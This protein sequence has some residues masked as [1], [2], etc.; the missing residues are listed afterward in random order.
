MTGMAIL[1]PAIR[2]TFRCKRFRIT[3]GNALVDTGADETLLPLSMAND[4]GF[5]FD[6]EKDKVMWDGAGGQQFPA[7]KS[8][9]EIEFI[10]E[11]SGF[12]PCRWTSHVFFT[13]EQPTI[14]IG[15][16]NFLD[17]FVVT[18]RGK[19]KVLELST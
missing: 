17:R 14:L 9:E 19:E 6:L 1:F 11:S 10:L 16:R 2:V 7:Y 15:R 5:D 18:F 12:R 4:M 3:I 8:P 13:L